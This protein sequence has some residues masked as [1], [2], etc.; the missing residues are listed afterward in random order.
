MNL[1]KLLLISFC[2]TWNIAYAESSGQ[3][4][5]AQSPLNLSNGVL[6]I[7]QSSVSTNGFLSSS[8]WST[9][10]NKQASGNYITAL[11]GD[12]TATGPGSSISTISAGA[13]VD[14]KVSSTA[15]IQFTK[16]AALQPKALTFGDSNGFI[17]TDPTNFYYDNTL[18]TAFSYNG[19]CGIPGSGNGTSLYSQNTSDSTAVESVYVYAGQALGTGAAGQIIIGG[20][21]TSGSQPGGV[22]SINAGSST[23]GPQGDIIILG[24]A[25]VSPNTNAGGKVRVEGGTSYGPGNG[26]DL[27]LQGG[28][29]CGTGSG[30]LGN[31]GNIYLQSGYSQ[32]AG[33]FTT[34]GA[35]YVQT[36]NVTQL[37]IGS[38]GIITIG[39]SG[40]T[41]QHAINVSTATPGTG[42]GSITNL[43]SGYSGNPTGYMQFTING[44]THVIPYW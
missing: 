12:V 43:P 7:P 2:F 31:N 38:T 30:S 20:G 4:I 13:I 17:T 10:N 19:W 5:N 8:D 21:S 18:Q 22:V 25:S 37:S 35:I 29:T 40:S 44:A 42:V 32:C 1:I 39:A 3:I 24:A 11:T 15:G 27:L 16:M 41:N 9:F 36:N 28:G 34:P 23:T 6:S 33:P 14:S 26:G